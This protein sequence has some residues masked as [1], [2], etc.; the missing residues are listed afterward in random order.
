MNVTLTG[1]TDSRPTSTVPDLSA[2]KA[3]A[4]AV[5]RAIL[6]RAFDADIEAMRTWGVDRAIEDGAGHRCIQESRQVD[7]EPG[8]AHVLAWFVAEAAL[9]LHEARGE[10]AASIRDPRNDSWD[11]EGWK[12]VN[13]HYSEILSARVISLHLHPEGYADAVIEVTGEGE[14]WS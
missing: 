9:E 11:R 3:N 7:L 13:V 4:V 14:Y 5:L 2:W 10:Y 12:A 8:E 6:K 1:F